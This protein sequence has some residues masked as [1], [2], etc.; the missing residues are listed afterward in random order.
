MHLHRPCL[1][2]LFVAGFLALGCLSACKTTRPSDTSEIT[3]SRMNAAYAEMEATE[4]S[5]LK[6]DLAEIIRERMKCYSEN[7]MALD[8]VRECR[9]Q[10][11]LQI[12]ELCRDRILSAPMLG[13]AILCFQYCPISN[14]V[15]RGDDIDSP[16]VDCIPMESK[17]IEYCLDLYWRG[18]DYPP[19]IPSPQ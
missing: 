18:G 15:C 12:V 6:D 1:L 2:G 13:N 5:A 4:L 10:Y 16:S 11:V 3:L 14:A 7:P 9:K 17:C 19:V 8:R